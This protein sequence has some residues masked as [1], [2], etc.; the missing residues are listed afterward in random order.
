MDKN[1]AIIIAIPRFQDE[2]APC[3]EAAVNF[4]VYTIPKGESPAKNLHLCQGESPLERVRLLRREKVDTLICGGLQSFYK[5]ML[6]T[7]GIEVIDGAAGAVEEALD[8]YLSARLYRGRNLRT[9][10]GY[11]TGKTPLLEELIIWT[12]EHFDKHGYEVRDGEQFAAFPVDLVALKKCPVC[13]KNVK[14]AICCGAHTYLAGKEIKEFYHVAAQWFEAYVYVHSAAPEVEQICRQYGIELLDPAF[15]KIKKTTLKK[16]ST[17]A[18]PLLKNPVKGH[19]KAY[20]TV[21]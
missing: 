15:G 18:F 4:D 11:F 10:Q 12:R 8:S 19:E 16:T 17:T 6:E 21:R 3:F 13:G 7:D 2:I 5:D 14:I 1:Q 9:R 20:E